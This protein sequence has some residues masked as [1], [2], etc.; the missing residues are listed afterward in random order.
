MNSNVESLKPT[1]YNTVGAKV[2]A[3][4][5]LTVLKDPKCWLFALINAGVATGIA[6][7]GLF[8]PTFV[9]EFGFSRGTVD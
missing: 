8:L 5:F 3:R 6:S 1:A 2:N 4:Q 9:Q 7:V